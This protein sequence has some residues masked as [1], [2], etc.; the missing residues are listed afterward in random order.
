MRGPML[1]DETAS[2]HGHN[3]IGILPAK[4]QSPVCSHI[5]DD[6]SRGGLCFGEERNVSKLAEMHE[7]LRAAL[8]TMQPYDVFYTNPDFEVLLGTVDAAT[9]STTPA[10]HARQCYARVA[11]AT[12]RKN[13]TERDKWVQHAWAWSRLI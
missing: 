4:G 6:S 3:S 13:W 10:E 9:E 2:T 7:R 5:P 11:E 8:R 1:Y 12:E